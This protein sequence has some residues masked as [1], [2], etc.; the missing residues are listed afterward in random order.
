MQIRAHGSREG[1]IR[2]LKALKPQLLGM[3]N[4]RPE[5]AKA[6]KERNSGIE[7]QFKAAVEFL[8]TEVSSIE[9]EFNG[10][11]VDANFDFHEGGRHFQVTILP[12][13]LSI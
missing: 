5:S 1:V 11:L 12:Q 9:P 3:E 2:E 8:V 6:H 10:C 13:K 4:V 7:A